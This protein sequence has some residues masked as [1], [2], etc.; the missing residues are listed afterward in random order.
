MH[1]PGVGLKES[2]FLG[3]PFEVEAIDQTTKNDAPASQCL[4][5]SVLFRNI[6]HP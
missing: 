5:G 3:C 2:R 6:Y 1:E 4:A